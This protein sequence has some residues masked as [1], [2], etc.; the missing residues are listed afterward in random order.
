MK[1]N[2]TSSGE[3][4]GDGRVAG[5]SASSGETNGD[6]RAAG[7]KAR[8]PKTGKEVIPSWDGTSPIRDYKKRVDLF[9]STTAIDEEYRAGR[10]VEQLS[11]A[12]WRAVDTM[13]VSLLRHPQG[14]DHLL[15]NLRSE[16]EPV[17]FLQTFGVL[18]TFYKQFK[19]SRG[20]SFIEFDNR[21]RVQLQK[22]K[23]VDAELNELSKA[24]WFLET[25]I[26]A[27]GGN[28]QYE[29]LRTALISIV[30]SVKRDDAPDV[31]RGKDGH[32]KKVFTPRGRPH[33]VNV[34]A[35]PTDEAQEP[36]HEPNEEEDEVPE[37]LQELERQAEVLVTQAS[38]RRAEV[39]KRRGYS[40]PGPRESSVEREN[41]IQRMKAHMACSACRAHGKVVYGHWHNDDNCPYI[42]TTMTI[43][44]TRRNP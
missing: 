15:A 24:Y 31:A 38:K 34:V 21:Y 16:L 27:S 43:V 8:E 39:E 7:T 30:P 5:N 3:T 41:R 37:D 44:P 17:E 4:N 36:L 25:V 18:T 23:E 20:E 9:L 10:L 13:D 6:G 11:G 33:G 29:R 35:E 40:R 12:A 26:S 22:L 19:R 42:G 1:S 2:S 14:V 28:L 32:E